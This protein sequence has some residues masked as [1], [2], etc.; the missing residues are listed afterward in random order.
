M[1]DVVLCRMS[2]CRFALEVKEQHTH[3]HAHRLIG[4]WGSSFLGW[5]VESNW[6]CLGF[7]KTSHVGYVITHHVI[8]TLQSSNGEQRTTGYA[9]A[10]C[11]E[12][13]VDFTK[14]ILH[15]DITWQLWQPPTTCTLS[16]RCGAPEDRAPT[17]PVSFSLLLVSLDKLT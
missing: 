11:P 3:T 10:E 9:Q 13:S 2:P 6:W 1:W 12:I 16:R 17:V 15:T 7:V 14:K 4:R 8:M 5:H